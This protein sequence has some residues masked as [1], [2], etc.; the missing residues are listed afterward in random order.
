MTAV[1]TDKRRADG[2]G[3]SIEH[4]EHFWDGYDE[5]EEQ[6]WVEATVETTDATVTPIATIPVP[7]NTAWLIE[8]NVSAKEDDSTTAV[9]Y[10]RTA[11]IRRATGNAVIADNSD[12]FDGNTDH[13][14]A[15]AAF[16]V[17]GTNLLLNVTGV[18]ATALDWK[19]RYRVISAL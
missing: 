8:A 5:L 9:G 7:E 4:N 13:V 10:K 19:A 17:S 16:A 11:V 1:P 15:T 12:D 2:T 3:M 6:K 14:T 18:A